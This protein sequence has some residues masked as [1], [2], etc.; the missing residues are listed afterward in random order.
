[1]TLLTPDLRHALRANDIGRRAALRDE[2]PEPDP[3]PVV[4]IFNPFGAATWLATELG[5]DDDTLFGLAD[6]GFGCPEL[7]AFRLSEMEA[8]RLPGGLGLERDL[9]FTARFP[10]S[11]YAEAARIAGS[12]IE[13]M[14][15]LSTIARAR[16]LLAPRNHELPPNGG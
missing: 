16:G 12:I 7:G 9:Y 13:A 5:A 6:L 10:L 3:V 8:I 2:K 4:K 11:V 14:P 15:L 1:M